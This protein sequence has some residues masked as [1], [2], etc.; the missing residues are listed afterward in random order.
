ND[1][2]RQ[3][4]IGPSITEKQSALYGGN[5]S[6]LPTMFGRDMATFNGQ[7][8]NWIWNTGTNQPSVDQNYDNAP[9]SPLATVD[10]IPLLQLNLSAAAQGPTP[11]DLNNFPAA[12][13]L[14]PDPDTNTT[15]PDINS[16]FLSY[17][18]LV[19]NPGSP[20]LPTRV[21]IPSFHRPQL[22]RNVT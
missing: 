6:L 5:K 4:I 8:V 9:D 19:P 18:A 14:Y 13:S 11:V 15:Y 1:V 10:T 21:I 12:G 20:T 22:L 2:L 3:I 16:A 7:G 17:D